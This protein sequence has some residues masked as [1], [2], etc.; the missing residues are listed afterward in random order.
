MATAKEIES[1]EFLKSRNPNCEVAVKD[2]RS[3]ETTVV[4]FKPETFQDFGKWPPTSHVSANITAAP[5]A[6]ISLPHPWR[7]WRGRPLQALN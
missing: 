5:I 2:L 7:A 6:P 3:E 4:A 1:A